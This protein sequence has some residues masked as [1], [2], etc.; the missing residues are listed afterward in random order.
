VQGQVVTRSCF[1]ISV[2]TLQFSIVPCILAPCPPFQCFLNSLCHI[3]LYI[4]HSITMQR[5]THCCRYDTMHTSLRHNIAHTDNVLSLCCVS[6]TVT[7][8][9][10]YTYNVSTL[11]P[12]VGDPSHNYANP[13]L[14]SRVS[15][16]YSMHPH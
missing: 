2:H 15:V 5:C 11:G 13:Y 12:F 3:Y 10:T 6:Y 14:G 9:Y 16:M 7:H 1:P 4:H 8:C